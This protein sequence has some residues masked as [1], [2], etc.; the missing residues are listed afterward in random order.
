MSLFT[1]GFQSH[2]QPSQKVAIFG[3]IEKHPAEG[4][5]ALSEVPKGSTSKARIAL[6]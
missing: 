3:G 1:A 4:P 2:S 5:T 6:I